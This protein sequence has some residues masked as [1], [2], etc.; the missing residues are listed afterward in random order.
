MDGRHPLLQGD[1]TSSDI[2]L[3]LDTWV[4]LPRLGKDAF[5]ELMK[6]GAEYSTGRGF[7]IRSGI[8]LQSAKRIISDAVGGR[9]YFV[10]KC[11]ICGREA[12]CADC[13]YRS[14]CAVE[15]VGGRCVCLKCSR[16][17]L[18]AY[19]KKWLNP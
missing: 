8:D 16:E 6:A 19:R 5:R 12:S 14:I 11:F 9:V 13:S 3:A 15:M 18:D 10:F 7:F 17:S 4:S 1:L 2:K